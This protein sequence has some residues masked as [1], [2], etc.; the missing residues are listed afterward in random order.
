MVLDEKTDVY[1]KTFTVKINEKNELVFEAYERGQALK[2][3]YGEGE[4]ERWLTVGPEFK[5]TV[6]L[7]LIKEQ[8]KSDIELKAWLEKKGIPCKMVSF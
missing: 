3:A 2:D 7:N 6:L 4:D 1:H 5:D 8:F